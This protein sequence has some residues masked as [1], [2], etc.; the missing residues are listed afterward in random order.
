MTIFLAKIPLSLESGNWLLHHGRVL[1]CQSLLVQEYLN[2][3]CV[4]VLP[5]LSAIQIQL[6]PLP[7]NEIPLKGMQVPLAEQVKEATEMAYK[8]T[9][10]YLQACFYQL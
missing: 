8:I 10:K 7:E 6:L 5:N 1:V 9:G 3:S 2:K 4:T